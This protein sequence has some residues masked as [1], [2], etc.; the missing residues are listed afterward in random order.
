MGILVDCKQPSKEIQFLSA[1]KI[2]HVCAMLKL[3]VLLVKGMAFENY[4]DF[5]ALLNH[6]GPIHLNLVMLN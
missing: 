2:F 1:M 5:S 6:L 3:T 4:V